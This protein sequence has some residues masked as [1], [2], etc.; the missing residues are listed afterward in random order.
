MNQVRGRYLPQEER[1]PL[2]Q[3]R[4]LEEQLRAV[5]QH[6]LRRRVHLLLQRIRPW[7]A[8]HRLVMMVDS[9]GCSVSPT[10]G[11]DPLALVLGLSLF[12]RA[13]GVG[14]RFR[15]SSHLDDQLFGRTVLNWYPLLP[16][17]LRQDTPER[18]NCSRQKSTMLRLREL[19]SKSEITVKDLNIEMTCEILNR[20]MEYELAGWC[21][22]HIMHS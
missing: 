11:N 17:R 13:D 18:F 9:G 7:V 4:R 16:D 14:S 10:G 5:G 21:A 1:R 3:L 12:L 20:I 22:T 2:F 19:L 8:Q 15:D 6:H